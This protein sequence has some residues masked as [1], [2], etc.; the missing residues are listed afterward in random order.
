MARILAVDVGGTQL[1]AAVADEHGHLFSRATMLTRAS[2]GLSAVL[3]RIGSVAAEAVAPVGWDRVDAVGVA[4]PGPLD[5]V[6]GVV[7]GAPN[8]PGWEN[9]PLRDELARR[10]GKPVVVGNDANVAALA[11]HRFGAGRGL[12]HLIYIT[13]S[14]GIGGGMIV[15]G[16]LLLGAR[17]LAGEVGHMV[18]EPLGPRCGCGNRGCLEALASGTAIGRQAREQIGAGAE[19]G[20]LKFAGG[21]VEKVTAREVSQAAQAGD[22]LALALLRR[23]G[24]YLGLGIYN[25][26][27]LLNPEAVVLGGSVMKAGDLLFDPIWETVRAVTPRP[28]WEALR[29]VPAELGDDVGLLGAL[30][31]VLHEGLVQA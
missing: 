3:A 16:K 26:L 21:V 22:E 19:T 9:V 29:I 8:L 30:A 7:L 27:A 1:R 10:T 31:L 23:A 13:V 2:E 28:Y 6:A 24:Y 12:R 20:I 17:G 15:D 4:A 14:T 5:P 11:E 25:L 18:L